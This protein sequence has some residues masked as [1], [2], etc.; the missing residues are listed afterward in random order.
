MK[1]LSNCSLTKLRE[2]RQSYGSQETLNVPY[3]KEFANEI[4]LCNECGEHTRTMK[5][6]TKLLISFI[7]KEITQRQLIVRANKAILQRTNK[8]LAYMAANEIAQKERQ[9]IAD[10][11]AAKWTDF[12]ANN[13]ESK[14]KY[15]AK[16]ETMSSGKWR[17]YLRLK[18]A[19]HING[20]S[21]QHLEISAPQLKA[22]LYA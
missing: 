2:Y 5:K 18:A 20:E 22:A 7:G 21:F 11:Q 10:A 14:A 3:I 17:N 13:P 12:L 15:I 4:W 1:V 6:G 9:L 8:R 16:C 19:K